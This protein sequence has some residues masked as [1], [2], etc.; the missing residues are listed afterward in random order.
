VNQWRNS[1]CHGFALHSLCNC[2]VFFSEKIS[3][4]DNVGTGNIRKYVLQLFASDDIFTDSLAHSIGDFRPIIT[5]EVAILA[6]VGLKGFNSFRF[7]LDVSTFKWRS[8]TVAKQPNVLIKHV[9][10]KSISHETRLCGLYSNPVEFAFKDF[11]HNET[12]K[13]NGFSSVPAD[14]LFFI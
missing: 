2:Q 11:G 1:R 13:N 10:K 4:N 12:A 6:P 14:R 3:H 8:A 7:W 9:T 5:L